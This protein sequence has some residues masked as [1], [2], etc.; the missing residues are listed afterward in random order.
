M[1]SEPGW[2][3]AGG[4]EL[5]GADLLRLVITKIIGHLDF[6]QVAISKFPTISKRVE[7]LEN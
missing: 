6:S 1:P 3:L 7:I 5:A 2:L 4:R